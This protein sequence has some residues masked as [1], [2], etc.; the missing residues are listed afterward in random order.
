MA[1]VDSVLSLKLSTGKEDLVELITSHNQLEPIFTLAGMSRY[2]FQE[3]LD[4]MGIRESSGEQVLNALKSAHIILP[5]IDGYAEAALPEESGFT[6][7]SVKSMQRTINRA[8]CQKRDGVYIIDNIL[9]NSVRL[10]IDSWVRALPYRKLDLDRVDVAD[11]H[12]IY[13]MKPVPL[14]LRSIPFLRV[15][16]D[17]VTHNYLSNKQVARRAYVYAGSFNDAYHSHKDYSEAGDM[18]AVYYPSPW[19]DSW[20]GELLIY[21]GCEPRWSF[22]P[23]PGRLI[24]FHGSRRHRIAPISTVAKNPR[25]SIVLRYG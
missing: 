4:L 24:I 23:K 10:S 9:P 20:G 2:E 8:L 11:L 14:F 19:G 12:W 25:Y 17:Y 18:T 5:T 6:V 13:N 3:Y 21:D 7:L 15:L 22:S 1:T 16:D